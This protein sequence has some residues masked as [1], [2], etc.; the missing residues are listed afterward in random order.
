M[1]G[2]RGVF[3]IESSVSPAPGLSILTP[4]PSLPAP[5]QS[6]LTL[7]LGLFPCLRKRSFAESQFGVGSGATG[8][9]RKQYS[10]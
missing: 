1:P 4:A 2:T 7:A 8:V 10:P 5:C 9:S 6:L 3:P